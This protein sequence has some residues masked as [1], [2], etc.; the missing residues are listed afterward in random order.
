M[1]NTS[2]IFGQEPDSFRGG[3]D[4]TQ[5]YVGE[6]AEFNIWNYALKGQ[7]ISNMASCSSIPKGN[8][9]SWDETSWV[10]HDAPINREV[11]IADFCSQ[12]IQ[13]I[14][15]PEKVRF[16]EARKTCEIHG[17]SLALP[18]SENETKIILDIVKCH[19]DR[20]YSFL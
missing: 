10:Y 20:I 3:F 6:L 1:L 13:Y 2:L 7:D 4:R 12:T 15:F 16:P 18:R 9:V 19:H 17:G 8:V 14:I 5:C 11:E